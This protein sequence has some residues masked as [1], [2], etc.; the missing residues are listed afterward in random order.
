MYDPIV[1]AADWLKNAPLKGVGLGI[2]QI[3]P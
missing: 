3:F 2:P 1:V